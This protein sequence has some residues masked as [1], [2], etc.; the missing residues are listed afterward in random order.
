MGKLRFGAAF[1]AISAESKKTER[2]IKVPSG[3]RHST[4]AVLKI[5]R[6]PEGKTRHGKTIGSKYR[7]CWNGS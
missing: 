4:T 3:I 7:Y 6:M 2:S 1:S 5:K